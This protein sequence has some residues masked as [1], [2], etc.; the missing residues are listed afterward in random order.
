MINNETYYFEY[1]KEKL[2]LYSDK[3]GNNQSCGVFE[4]S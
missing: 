3:R 1:V 4:H 2:K